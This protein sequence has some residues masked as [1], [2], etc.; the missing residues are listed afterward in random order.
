MELALI[1]YEELISL[2]CSLGGRFDNACIR[3]SDYG[4]GVFSV[5]PE[6]RVVVYAPEHLLFLTNNLVVDSDSKLGLLSNAG[7]PKAV[8]QFFE[9]YHETLGWDR[10]I[11]T[12][13]L[14]QASWFAIPG[15]VKEL[16]LKMGVLTACFSEPNPQVLLSKYCRER[17]ISYKKNKINQ[18]FLMPMVE[19]LNHSSEG[20]SFSIGNGVKVEATVNDELYVD[21]GAHT[22][23]LQQFVTYNFS[24]KP[25]FIYSIPIS[26]SRRSS[27][28]I[29]ISSSPPFGY[30][31]PPSLVLKNGDIHISHLEIY[32]SNEQEKPLRSFINLMKA[33]GLRESDSCALFNLII[34]QNKNAF[35]GLKSLLDE[36]D[37][38]LVEKMKL[39]VTHQ[40]Q[41]IENAYR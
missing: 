36:S 10:A 13:Q 34:E 16:L 23:P 7:I 5:E 11:D 8:E 1:N 35:L 15:S 40:L 9:L 32:N 24:S 2:F 31:K 25:E 22:D 21:Y 41:G 38:S 18:F 4:L 28:S 30:G 29:F 27:G 20:K 39:M 3:D 6:K 17:R 33:Y 14:I 26:L 12:I 37:F 19:I